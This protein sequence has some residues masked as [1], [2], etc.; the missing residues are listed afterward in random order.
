MRAIRVCLVAA[1]V[2]CV[3]A[4]PAKAGLFSCLQGQTLTIPPITIPPIHFAPVQ[5]APMVVQQPTA[6]NGL[7]EI[8]TA[9]QLINSIF[10]GANNGGGNTST[11]DGN[12][13]SMQRASDTLD[14]IDGKMDK[15]QAL[16]TDRLN[17]TDSDVATVAKAQRESAAQLEQ[18]LIATTN[19]VNENTKLIKAN[20]DA[21]NTATK[22]I[23]RTQ[24]ETTVLLGQKSLPATKTVDAVANAIPATAVLTNAAVT[25]PK[26][27]MVEILG[28]MTGSD[29]TKLVLVRWDDGG[30]KSIATAK[31]DDVK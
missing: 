25:I 22:A 15:L 30:T 29:G 8:L 24:Q 20:A 26:G 3:G 1:L 16:I 10:G 28:E 19:L 18:R 11:A 27:T 9:I 6:Q 7:V 23:Q 4:G 14:R 5:S 2:V 12:S 13:G 31:S 17:K 21:I